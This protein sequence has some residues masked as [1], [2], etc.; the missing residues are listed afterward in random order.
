MMRVIALLVAAILV[1]SGCG[2]SSSDSSSPSP[3]STTVATTTTE[4]PTT[5]TTEAGTIH[6]KEWANGFCSAFDSWLSAINTSTDQLSTEL[7]AGPLAGKRSIAKLFNDAKSQTAMLIASIDDLGKPQVEGGSDL[8]QAMRDEF[9]K[10]E[11]A[12]S[13]AAADLEKLDPTSRTFVQDARG[14]ISDFREKFSAVGESFDQ[15]DKEHRS[16]ELQ[17]AI[18]S[19]C[20]SD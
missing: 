16:D 17:A 20:F 4:A 12:S 3:S 7:R 2:D 11:E 19:A 6:A 8:V 15:I 5:T 14:L 10:F 1:V 13:S 9:S 18:T